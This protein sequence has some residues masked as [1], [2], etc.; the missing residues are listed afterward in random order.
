MAL[1]QG[2]LEDKLAG[3]TGSP[4]LPLVLLRLQS[5]SGPLLVVT[6]DPEVNL[7][8]GDPPP[9]LAW[10]SCK[11]MPKHIKLSQVVLWALGAEQC[12]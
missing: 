5:G 1:A 7:T 4:A 11:S 12:Q 6:C 2:S 8:R 10:V 3:D 9:S